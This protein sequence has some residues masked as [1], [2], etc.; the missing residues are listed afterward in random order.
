MNKLIISITLVL[1]GV[2]CG[3]SKSLSTEQLEN[4]IWHLKSIAGLSDEENLSF[5][6]AML[7]FSKDD[8]SYSGN[9]GCNMISGNF[10]ISQDK[11]TFGEGLSTRKFCQGIDEQ[12]FHNVLNLT[13]R[14]QIKDDVLFLFENDKKLA[15]FI[16]E[17]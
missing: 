2:S 9:N 4:T 11:V 1:F 15:E 7:S 10:S 13:N 14:M 16:R 3:T 8:S 12:K 6:D 5:K 17:Q